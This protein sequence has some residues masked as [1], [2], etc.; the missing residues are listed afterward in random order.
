MGSDRT[1]AMIAEPN[2][3]APNDDATPEG[4]GEA[5]SANLKPGNTSDTRLIERAIKKR[6]PISEEFR[7]AVVTQLVRIL[8]DPTSSRREKTS[9]AR[10]LLS[11]EHQ[12][13]QDEF[14]IAPFENRLREMEPVVIELPA[15]RPLLT[16]KTGNGNGNE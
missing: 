7:A 4:K 10:A 3:N 6:W 11:A 15:K 1:E 2:E 16:D 14:A 8:A 5:V 13:Q 12:N 9:A